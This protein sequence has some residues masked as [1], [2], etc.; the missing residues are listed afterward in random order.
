MAIRTSKNRILRAALGAALLAACAC[1]AVSCT[2]VIGWGVVLWNFDS[3]GAAPAEASSPEADA[4]PDSETFGAEAAMPERKSSSVE[5]IEGLANGQIV[6]I[7]VKSN[8]QNSYIIGIPGSGRKAELPI[9][10]I[11]RFSSK[12]KAMAFRKEM[13]PCLDLW[14]IATRNAL[15][16]RASPDTNSASRQVYRLR[17]KEMLKMLKKVAGAEV[18]TGDK[19]LEGDWYQALS[20]DGTR[21]Y[22]FSNTLSLLDSSKMSVLQSAASLDQKKRDE[23]IELVLSKTWRPEI[24]RKMIDEQ[25]YDLEEFSMRYGMFSDMVKKQ[26]RIELPNLSKVF[27]YTE[28]VRLKPGLFGFQGTN[29]QIQVRGDDILTVS[30]PDDNGKSKAI[31][32][33]LVEEDME[34]LSRAEE[35]RRQAILEGII[36]KGSTLTSDTYGELVLSASRRFTWKGYDLLSP[37]AIPGG[38]GDSGEIA[39]DRYV[40]DGLSGAFDGVINFMF[41]SLPKGD[42]VRFYYK[43]SSDGMKLEQMPPD[44]FDATGLTAIKRGSGPI[45]AFFSFGS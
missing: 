28:S 36:A 21:G 33:V 7:Y 44:A 31:V 18:K 12:S 5:Y 43:M 41:D 22:V 1:F 40:D 8:I 27:N 2:P 9:W 26:I 19:K 3:R 10:R 24:F 39:F 37:A 23:S 42:A 17:E 4:A 13:E 16:M 14:G 35:N 45:V 15:I 34:A 25:R 30:F 6:P 11:E 29:L 20:S 38:M 32:M